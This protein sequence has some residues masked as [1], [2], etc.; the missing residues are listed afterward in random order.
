LKEF[1]KKNGANDQPGEYAMPKPLISEG[2]V[3][4]SLAK[5][6]KSFSSRMVSPG[7]LCV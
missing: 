6:K 4:K 1:N 5:S 7:G 2:K 3:K